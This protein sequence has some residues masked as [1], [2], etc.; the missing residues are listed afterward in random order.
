MTANPTVR[1]Y[2]AFESHCSSLANTSLSLKRPKQN[3][4]PEIRVYPFRVKM[5]E[6][7]KTCYHVMLVLN[8]S[9]TQNYSKG[10]PVLVGYFCILPPPHSKVLWNADTPQHV[11]R[12]CWVAPATVYIPGE[13]SESDIDLTREGNGEVAGWEKW[14]NGGG[15][16]LS[17]WCT[18]TGI[19]VTR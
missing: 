9:C 4:S 17:W 6:K 2:G 7:K 16:V 8:F 15:E 12:L 13:D 10:T 14:A 5:V 1:T 18:R 3:F 11:S 19:S